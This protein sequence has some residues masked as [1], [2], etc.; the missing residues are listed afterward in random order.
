L[1]GTQRIIDKLEAFAHQEYNQEI[2]KNPQAIEQAIRE[3]K[4]LFGRGFSYKFI[5]LDDAFPEYLVKHQDEF[6]ELIR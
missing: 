1:G 4:D 5:P 6:K 3:G 2:F